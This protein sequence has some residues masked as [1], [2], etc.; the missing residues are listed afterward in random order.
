MKISVQKLT[1]AGIVAAAYAALTILLA[2]IS[3]GVLQLRVSEVLCILPF[4]VPCTAWGLFVGC[5]IANLI[6]AFGP[7]DI[8]FGSLASLLAGLTVA[9]LGRGRG[10]ASVGRSVAAC[11]MPAV[12]NGPIIGCVIAASILDMSSVT[13][14]AFAAAA[15]INGAQIAAEELIVMFALGLPLM[16][17]LPKTRFFSPI[18]EKLQEKPDNKRV[19]KRGVS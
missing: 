13:P 1:A 2:P 4:F 15:L 3:Y 5:M 9:A 12:F 6:S 14:G 7:L 11:A 17:W 18:V 8:V 10:D 16:R 19:R